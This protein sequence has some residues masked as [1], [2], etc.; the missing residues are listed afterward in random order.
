MRSTEKLTALAGR[1]GT[2]LASNALVQGL[3]MLTGL[4]ILWILPVEQYALYITCSALIAV[5]SVGSDSGISQALLTLGSRAFGERARVSDIFVTCWRLRR[6]ALLVISVLVLVAAVAMGYRQQWS[7]STW[8][9]VLVMVMATNWAQVRISPYGSLFNIYQDTR[10]IFV[11][12][13][14]P[15]A[16]RLVLALS[17]CPSWPLAGTALGINLLGFVLQDF[18]AGRLA[19][20]YLDR[21]SAPSVAIRREVERFVLPLIPG[22]LYYIFQGQ[23]AV[24]LLTWAGQTTAI[25]EVGALGRLLQVFVL[26]GALNSFFV[27]PYFSR[28][29][30]P[31]LF[32]SRLYLVGLVVALF[33]AAVLG[34]AFVF[35]GWWILILGAKYAHMQH[36]IPLAVAGCL[37]TIFGSTAYSIVIAT[38]FTRYQWFQ[39]PLGIGIQLIVMMWVG[40]Q[41]T[42]D[43]LL[44]TYGPALSYAMLQLAILG[45]ALRQLEPTVSKALYDPAR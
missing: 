19:G 34:S 11:S 44:L 5:G 35:D 24:F 37:V 28:L 29:T 25:A 27:Q 8:L 2:F 16:L 15:A 41:S 13:A 33:S 9:V 23:I 26:L 4:A 18:V 10:S 20:K 32:R 36:L 39:I 45:V 42:R 21:A 3:N 30:D 43:A 14:L 38:K 1:L 31:R 17:L 40:V 12:T 6:Q 7:P 22:V